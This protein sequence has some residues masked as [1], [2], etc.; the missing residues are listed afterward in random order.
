M[1]N[2]R[3]PA[4]KS[5]KELI[6]YK[7]SAVAAVREYY[8]NRTNIPANLL[9]RFGNGASVNVQVPVDIPEKSEVKQTGTDGGAREPQPFDNVDYI[10]GLAFEYIIDI[11]AMCSLI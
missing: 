2:I 10:P 6:D 9:R 5:K 11:A 3:Y 4:H 7:D 1:Q 8:G